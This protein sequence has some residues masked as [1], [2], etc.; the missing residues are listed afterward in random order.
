MSATDSSLVVNKGEDDGFFSSI[1]PM[2]A[3]SI[4]GIGAVVTIIFMMIIIWVSG[5]TKSESFNRGLQ[6][7]NSG[8]QL[9]FFGE[10][11]D[12][13]KVSGFVD[14]GDKTK[15]LWKSRMEQFSGGR[16]APYFPNVTNR[17]LRTENREKN[18]VRALGKINQE[19]M[20]RRGEEPLPWGPFWDEWKK[21]H[22]LDDDM[23]EGYNNFRERDLLPYV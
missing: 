20:R 3:V 15:G 4:A 10:P 7:V 17:V 19:R 16:E 23:T 14:A 22:P 12:N 8:P 11:S 9:R 21:T 6:T 2:Q 13:M 1:E 18:A 5:K